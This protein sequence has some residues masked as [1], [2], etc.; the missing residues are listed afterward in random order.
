MR[1]GRLLKLISVVSVAATL[2]AGF[3][4]LQFSQRLAAAEMELQ[5]AKSIADNVTS[6]L[7]IT[8]DA[9]WEHSERAAEQWWVRHTDI[10]N[11]LESKATESP[12]DPVTVLLTGLRERHGR[13]GALFRSVFDNSV[14]LEARLMARRRSLLVGQLLIEVEA[15]VEDTNRWENL[16]IEART[17]GENSL[18]LAAKAL[19]GVFALALVLVVGVAMRRLIRP[20]S[21]LEEVS[22]SVALGNFDMKLSEGR[23]D[24]FGDVSR[25]FNQMTGALQRQTAALL[26][27]RDVAE[28][29]MHA[30][31]NFLATMSHEIRTPM[32]GILGM[33]KLLQH[34]DLTS[35]QANYARN[36]EGATQ[37]LLS[38]IND[39]LDFSK[40][41]AGKLELDS[42]RF[43]L[44]DLL[45]ELSVMLSASGDKRPVEVLF[46]V[47]PGVPTA[48]VGD[49]LRLR[50][51][52]INLAGNALKFT[53]EGD[54][55]V[56]IRLVATE[57]SHVQLEFG[58]S[59]TGIGISQDKLG[60]IF[61]GFSQAESST[62]RRFGGTG[63]GLAISK[64]LVNLMGGELRVESTVGKGSR[65]FFQ[66]PLVVAPAPVVASSVHPPLPPV[67]PLRV[68]VIDDYPLAR[69]I[70][71]A[72]VES[73]GWICTCVES[74]EAALQILQQ[75]HR[76]AYQLIVVDWYM[77]GMDGWETTRRIRS[78]AH[79][80]MQ[81]IILLA[82]GA[83]REHLNGRSP[84][85][86]E[87][88]NGT[89]VKP[90]TTDMLHDAVRQAMV[91]QVGTPRP[92]RATLDTTRLARLRLLVVEDNALNQ[93][94]AKELLER[95]GA[96][97][98]IAESGMAGVAQALAAEPAFDVI[99]MDLQMPDI[100][101]FEATRRIHAVPRLRATPIIAMTAN[102]ME[103]DKADCRAAGMCDHIG[104]PIDLEQ[105]I[106]AILRQVGRR[107]GDADTMPFAEMQSDPSTIVDSA[108]AIERLGG[109]RAFYRTI[110]DVFLLDAAVQYTELVQCVAQGDYA[111]ALR[112]AH[113]LK[114]LAATVGANPLA[115]AAAHTENVLKRLDTAD[116]QSQAL[117]RVNESL[118]LLEAQLLVASQT[119][120]T[121]AQ[122]A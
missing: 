89:L 111:T 49:A 113:T 63:L 9:V 97:V 73:L 48:M 121:I 120:S 79:D 80:G 21:Q 92:E 50:Q 8:N 6:L 112:N 100:D 104:K 64:R 5:R 122:E 51:I 103:S 87:M 32:N 40:V 95:S 53:E 94:V 86:L 98:A 57:L 1:V 43:A 116:F 90:L 46:S 30:K 28:A 24:E 20:L 58:V 18:L 54:V 75:P 29:A 76:Q 119:L 107:A 65:F 117:A 101:G 47:G 114:G 36:A 72:M 61:E 22:Q 33:L 82:T 96:Q 81:P 3:F 118:V 42:A 69:E 4:I 10:A 77:P 88:L 66:I 14:A 105:L 67:Q 34:T 106:N 39:I 41:D 60:Y 74:G 37:S 84:R 55:V 71:A 102:A 31:S 59:D 38:I 115:A 68:L 17:N 108:L 83:G 23:N 56:S 27:A 19:L 91:E 93:Q 109:S 12:D 2:T 110:V 44:G 35:Q 26:Q 13:I 99:L 15:M 52:L 45:R 7:L 62:T 25:A 78:L 11:H 16:A 85:E 70:M